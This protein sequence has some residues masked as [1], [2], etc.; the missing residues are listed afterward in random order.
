MSMKL[1]PNVLRALVLEWAEQHMAFRAAMKDKD[2]LTSSAEELNAV[3][4]MG[5]KYNA[6]ADALA[7]IVLGAEVDG[8]KDT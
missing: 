8:A 5:V 2:L 3:I 1:R 6:T 7:E 4:E